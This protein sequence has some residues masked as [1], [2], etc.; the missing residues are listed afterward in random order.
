MGAIRVVWGTGHGPT[1]TA[2]YD[3]ALAAAN[4]HNYNLVTVS[5]VIPADGTVSRVGTA[6]DL[7]P[8]G[9]RLTVVQAAATVAGPGAASAGLAWT[10]TEGPGLFYE[11]AGPTEEAT[12]EARIREGIEAGLDLRD[13]DGDPIQ[14]Q[15]ASA[16]AESGEYVS[17]VVLAVYGRAEPIC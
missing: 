2:A 17:S 8:I 3:A 10:P 9:H 4:V 13:W 5:S 11:S 14:V 6:P 1:E 16:A 7:G 15:T 12:I